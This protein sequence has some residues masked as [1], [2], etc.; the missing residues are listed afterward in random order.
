MGKTSG[1]ILPVGIALIIL[2]YTT[3]AVLSLTT[4]KADNGFADRNIDFNQKFYAAQA[5]FEKTYAKLDGILEEESRGQM[6][7][8]KLESAAGALEG[9]KLMEYS[10]KTVAFEYHAEISAEI[11]YSAKLV[12]DSG[13]GL[14]ITEKGIE[15]IAQWEDENYEVWDG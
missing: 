14:R 9:M 7:R 15:N 5:R 2:L 6:S 3:L 12:F 1:F 10:T 13:Q 4:A 11:L 8:E